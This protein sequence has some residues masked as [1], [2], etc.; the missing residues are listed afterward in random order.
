MIFKFFS[1]INNLLH[2]NINCAHRDIE[3]GK[4]EH[5]R[6]FTSNKN[7]CEQKK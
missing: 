4:R 6:G 1:K 3:T 2:A 7:V 5:F